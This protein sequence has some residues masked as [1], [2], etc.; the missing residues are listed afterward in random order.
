MQKNIIKKGDTGKYF[1]E[2]AAVFC[3]TSE[4]TPGTKSERKYEG[5]L[6]LRQKGFEKA[7]YGASEI[8]I[9]SNNKSIVI[10]QLKQIASLYPPRKDLTIIDMGELKHD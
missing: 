6:L 3:N 2:L 5:M 9:H 4:R 10:E 7:R 1:V 8:R